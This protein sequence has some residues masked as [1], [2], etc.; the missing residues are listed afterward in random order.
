[1]NK[2]VYQDDLDVALAINRPVGHKYTVSE[3]KHQRKVLDHLE[4]SG[5]FVTKVISANKAGGSDIWA[6]SPI[7]QLWL[8]EMKREDGVLSELQL[9]K[10]MN[11]HKNNIVIMCAYGYADY[12]AKYTQ[13][14]SVV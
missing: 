1:M 11:A 7:G 13:I 5:F 6:G 2:F 10:L 3:T 12:K 9:A 4:A 8:I 14:I